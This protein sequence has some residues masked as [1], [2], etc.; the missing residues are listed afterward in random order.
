MA[1][2][3]GFVGPSYQAASIYQD[4]QECINWYP[5]PD[6][7]KGDNERGVRALYPTPGLT[8]PLVTPQYGEVRGFRVIPGGATLFAVVGN[9]LYS[10]T[11]GYVATAVGVLNTS[12]GRVYMTDN[13]VSLYVTDGAN[14]YYYTWG[15]STFAVVT[16]G[17]FNGANVCDEID[18]YILYNYPGTTQWGCTNVGSISSSQNYLGSKIGSADNLITLIAWNRYVSLLGEKTSETWQDTGALAFPF[19]IIPGT[20]FQ[21]GIAALNS[22]A[23]LGESFAWLSKD[24][25]GQN[26]VVHMV[27]FAP[28]RIS[29]FAFED[30]VSKYSTTADAI[31][32]SYQQSGHEFYMLTF[33]SADVTWCFDLATQLWHKRAWRD[34][35]NVLHRHRANCLATFNEQVIV[36]DYENGSIYAFSQST[37]TDNGDAIPCIRRCPHLTDD[38]RQVFYHQLQIQFQPGV[39]LQTGQGSNPQAMLRWSD[40]GGSTYGNYH[41]AGIGKAG[42]YKNRAQWQRLGSARDRIFEVTVTDPVYR[43]VVSAN[44]NASPGVT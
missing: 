26:V 10:I 6:P 30:A 21:H 38:L 12:S 8:A 24:D 20:S 15:T 5:E 43:V 4:A 27:G 11:T 29:T 7:M 23:R 34:S 17:A 22:P 16:D 25:R 19:A 14:R 13:G 40:D 44:L 33:P 9:T 39:G 37:Y 2:F 35:A 1:D 3:L 32:M 42:N 28:Q 18:N 36:G 31:G 41:V